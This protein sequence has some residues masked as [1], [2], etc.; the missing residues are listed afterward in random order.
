M[1][2]NNYNN[3]NNFINDQLVKRKKRSKNKQKLIIVLLM[4][5]ILVAASAITYITNNESVNNA[6]DTQTSFIVLN[7]DSISLPVTDEGSARDAIKSIAD[8]IGMQ[9]ID[10]ELGECQEDTALGN[11]YYRF[12]QEYKNI[13]V[14]G[15]N[16]IVSADKEGKVLLLTGNYERVAS[17][18][19]EPVVQD[20][21]ALK[22]IEEEVPEESNIYCDGLIIYSLNS[23]EPELSWKIYY[24]SPGES[25]YYFV[26]AQDGEIITEE[27][28]IY[29]A[30]SICGGVDID[31]NSQNFYAEY[32]DGEYILKDTSREISIFDANDG[33]VMSECVIQDSEGKIYSYNGEIEKWQDASGNAV[34]IEG[35]NYSIIITDENGQVVGE[36]GEYVIRIWNQN[37][38]TDITPI[39]SNSQ[40]W[41]NKKAV[42]VMTG[43]STAYDFWQKELQRNSFDGKYGAIVGIINDHKSGA[44]ITN[45]SNN[46]YFSSIEPG[47]Y[48]P[49]MLL[50][51]GTENPL[52][53]NWIYHEFSH[54]VEHT[55][56]HLIDEGETGALKEAYADIFSET[57]EAWT[58]NGKCDWSFAKVRNLANPEENSMPNMYHGEFWVNTLDVS[59]SNDKGGVHT[60][61]TVISYTAHLMNTNNKDNSQFE[62]LSMDNIA[63]LFYSTMFLLPSDCTF[64]QFRTLMENQAKILQEQNLLTKGQVDQV[65][66]A[67]DQAGIIPDFL[68][69]KPTSTFQVFDVNGEVYDNYTIDVMQNNSLIEQ[70]DGSNAGND[71]TFPNEGIYGIGITDKTNTENR[72]VIVVYVSEFDGAAQVPLYTS[73]GIKSQDTDT[74][75]TQ[76]QTSEDET[77]QIPAETQQ[78]NSSNIDAESLFRDF[79]SSRAY[80]EYTSGWS[81]EPDGYAFVDINQ[82]GIVELIIKGSYGDDFSAAAVFKISTVDQSIINIG[83][84]DYC[85]NLQYSQEYKALVYSDTRPSAEESVD[86]FYSIQDDSLVFGFAVCWGLGYGIEYDDP[87]ITQY[88]DGLTN[89]EFNSLLDFIDGAG[90]AEGKVEL[91]GYLNDFQAIDELLQGN[92]PSRPGIYGIYHIADGYNIQYACRKGS[93]KIDFMIIEGN[94]T[95]QLFG[96]YVGQDVSIAKNTLTANGWELSENLTSKYF[97]NGSYITLE[98]D[99]NSNLITKIMYETL[100]TNTGIN[101]PASQSIVGTWESVIDSEVYRLVFT[102]DGQAIAYEP[103]GN[104]GFYESPAYYRVNEAAGILQVYDDYGEELEEPWYYSITGDTLTLT[105]GRDH[106]IVRT[107]YRVIE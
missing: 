36:N 46:I 16:V 60:N 56:S 88:T 99:N 7:G 72:Q 9:D 77:I 27:P 93:Q 87:A 58:N 51:F 52:G 32:E 68:L 95:Y 26:S 45:A 101:N 49:I 70:Y 4:A 33:N 43:I 73:F 23:H 50:Q 107:F 59:D 40:I 30:Q 42:T 104:G 103:D 79:I 82:D 67:F 20:T 44:D 98:W 106:D 64:G 90:E 41:D 21:E 29:T 35:D 66:N 25:K 53:Y 6:I 92:D 12:S 28:L 34:K 78:Q 8:L 71:V 65:S 91:S 54:G 86:N 39:T 97:S 75:V 15:R 13:P 80:E 74:D 61:S 63:D 11:T 48:I 22:I 85:Y 3:D 84:F 81:C 105:V 1:M 76:D 47:M 10:N 94:E 19:T 37:K 38:F 62:Q 14:Y 69:V 5:T 100:E 18:G 24:S 96:I 2:N 17:A 31:G 55:S 57:I 89:V 102:D 83:Q